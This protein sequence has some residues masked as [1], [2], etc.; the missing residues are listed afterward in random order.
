MKSKLLGGAAALALTTCAV[1]ASS[2]SASAQPYWY[3][4]F[5]WSAPALATGIIGGVVAEAAS[6]LWAPGY[7]GYFPGYAYAPL[8]DYVAPPPIVVTPAPAVVA[9]GDVAYCEA[10]FRSYDPATGMYL[11]Y[12]GLRH[13]CP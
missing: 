8:Y 13:P 1:L 2:E 6:P 9:G 12:D 4:S 3:E 11:G 5:G 10:H 7:Y